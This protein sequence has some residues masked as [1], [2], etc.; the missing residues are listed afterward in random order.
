[1]SWWLILILTILAIHFLLSLIF[2]VMTYVLRY[3]DIPCFLLNLF[4]FGSFSLLGII[5][6]ILRNAPEESIY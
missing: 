4:V 1:M 6:G 2:A 5:W 3:K